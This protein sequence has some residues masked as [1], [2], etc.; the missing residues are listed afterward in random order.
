MS[1]FRR[2]MLML[3]MSSLLGGCSQGFAFEDLFFVEVEEKRVC[4]QL[5]E[6]GIPAAEPGAR[7]IDT[8]IPFSGLPSDIGGDSVGELSFR[9]TELV[10]E[11]NDN[12]QLDLLEEAMLLMRPEGVTDPE[13]ARTLLLYQRQSG[14][15]GQPLRLQGDEVEITDLLASG[16]MEVVLRAKGELPEQPWTLR[17]SACW[18]IRVRINYLRA[19]LAMP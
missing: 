1:H 6:Q 9:V 11:T 5:G 15:Q 2:V 12:S 10:L 17:V 3:S 4:K 14:A 13:Q 8:V 18:G 16:P 7:E 19:A